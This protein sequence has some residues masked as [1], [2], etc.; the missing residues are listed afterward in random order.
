MIAVFD[1]LRVFS[2]WTV[3]L[4]MALAVISGAVIGYGRSSKR[5]NAGLRTYMLT[6]LGAATTVLISLFDNEMLNGAWKP[7]VDAVGVKFDASRLSQQVVNGIG[8]LAAGTIIAIAHRQV[9]GLTSA[10][11]LFASALL[12]IAVGAGYYECVLMAILL[13]IVTMEFMQPLEL[14]FKRRLRNITINVEFDTLEDMQLITDTI[15]S[16][17]AQVFDIDIEKS[18]PRAGECVSAILSVKM[19]RQHASHSSM[20]SSIAELDCVHSV[21][22]LIS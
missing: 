7:I 16:L 19:G 18:R 15:T 20:L 5:A 22:E 6:C 12:G 10:I 2:F 8:F 4:R 1:R 21:R 9:S 11:G 3:A 13:I 17:D 14:A